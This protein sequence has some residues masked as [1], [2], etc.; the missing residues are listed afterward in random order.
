MLKNFWKIF[1]VVAIIVIAFTFPAIVTSIA[2]WAEGVGFAGAL[3]ST[4]LVLAA[5]PVWAGA[6]VGLGLAYLIDPETTSEVIGQVGTAAGSVV[7]AVGSA[8]SSG[9][10]SVWGLLAAGGLAY[11]FFFMDDKKKKDDAEVAPV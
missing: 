8:V 3:T 6:V 7:A 9:L 5:L 4:K 1:L 11:Y 2:T 10:S